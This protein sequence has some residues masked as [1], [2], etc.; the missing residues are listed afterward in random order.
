MNVVATEKVK[1]L[2]SFPKTSKLFIIKKFSKTKSIAGG[3]YANF[4]KTD[5]NFVAP[6]GYKLFAL[7][8]F[9]T[10]NAAHVLTKID[11][12]EETNMVRV[13]NCGSE[14]YNC[15]LVLYFSFIKKEYANGFWYDAEDGLVAK[16]KIELYFPNIPSSVKVSS[17]DCW[18]DS[19]EIQI[20]GTYEI[21]YQYG[22]YIRMEGSQNTSIRIPKQGFGAFYTSS[23]GLTVHRDYIIGRITGSYT[24]D[25]EGYNIPFGSSIGTNRI[26]IY[27]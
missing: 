13:K 27:V 22:R 15:A 14:T 19:V 26:N 20:S 3:S 2:I 8:H 21:F 11:P 17:I 7:V 4:T 24:E 25:A 1:G 6:I 16:P 10:G 5:L 9:T 18:L 23:D 12:F